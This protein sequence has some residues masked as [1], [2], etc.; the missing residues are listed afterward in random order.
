MK[1]LVAVD[2]S[3]F[4]AAALRMLITQNQPEKAGVRV[5][6]VVEPVDTPFYPELTPPYPASLEDVRKGR[7]KAGR[8]LVARTVSDLREAG[9]EVDGVV[10]MGSPGPTVVD[11][12]SKWHADLIVVGSHGWKGL[13]RLLLG[14]VSDHIARHAPCSVE[15]VRPRRRKR[16]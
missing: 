12:A 1:I 11:A 5:L 13:T 16:G 10:K 7:M 4:S 15:I 9:F 2:S 3:K 6:H 14:S 8:E